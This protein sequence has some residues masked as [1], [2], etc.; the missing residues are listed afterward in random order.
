[1]VFKPVCIMLASFKHVKYIY[2]T[3]ERTAIAPGMLQLIFMF[4]LNEVYIYIYIGYFA[5]RST[6]FEGDSRKTI[7]DAHKC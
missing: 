6:S 7:L 5:T 4:L 3:C 1:M 2:C